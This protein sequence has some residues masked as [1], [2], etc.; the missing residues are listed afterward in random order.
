MRWKL[1]RGASLHRVYRGLLVSIRLGDH[2]VGLVDQPRDLRCADQRAAFI[3]SGRHGDGKSIRNASGRR[4]PAGPNS[5]GDR[6]ANGG[7]EI[8]IDRADIAADFRAQSE[9]SSPC[10]KARGFGRFFSCGFCSCFGGSLVLVR[11]RAFLD[12]FLVALCLVR[13]RGFDLYL[14]GHFGLSL[15]RRVIAL[16]VSGWRLGPKVEI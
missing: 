13:G 10:S 6:N 14:L 1:K 12:E 11:D 8:S 15:Q 2:H 5:S 7:S 16:R 9:G 4:V 3:E